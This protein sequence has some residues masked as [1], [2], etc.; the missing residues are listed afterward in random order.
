M[1]QAP[2]EQ[3]DFPSFRAV[4]DCGLL[5]TYGTVSSDAVAQQILTLDRRIAEAPPPGV[6][7]VVPAMV[8]LLVV[9]DPL[10]TDHD[11]LTESVRALA[12]DAATDDLAGTERVV[13]VCFDDDFAPDLRAVATAK[14]LSEE[15]VC[16]R[17][18]NGDFRV[19]MYGFAPG[20]AYMSGVPEAIR[21][22]RKSAAVRD[23]PAGSV[24]IAGEQCLVTTLTM[25]TGWSIIGRSPTK[26]LSRGSERPFLFDVGDPVRFRRISRAEYEVRMG[27]GHG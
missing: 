18:L 20:Y 21:V 1:T 13:E 23:V 11:S 3:E 25:P 10:V 2:P 5:V 22:P 24:I 7:E 27:E 15:A 4:G 6:C 8:N 19:R 14:S 12:R 9:F 26:V 17:F 16:E